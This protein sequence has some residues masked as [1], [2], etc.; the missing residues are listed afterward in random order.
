[1]RQLK[2]QSSQT[3]GI[4]ALSQQQQQTML[5]QSQMRDLNNQQK[6]IKASEESASKR[7]QTARPLPVEKLQE[8][9]SDK[10]KAKPNLT[11]AAQLQVYLK[12]EYVEFTN[13]LQPKNPQTIRPK[14]MNIQQTLRYID[15]IYT[16]RFLQKSSAR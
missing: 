16:Y 14:R 6:K 15:E 1:M 4:S 9:S 3:Q 10:K 2:K 11:S 13:F 7:P 5:L 12:P 8:S